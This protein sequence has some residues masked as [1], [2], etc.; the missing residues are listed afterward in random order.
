MMRE[1][2]TQRFEKV[3]FEQYASCIGDFRD[4]SDYRQFEYDNIKRPKRAT[5]GSAGY[6]FFAPHSFTLEVGQ[7]IK[8]PTGIRVKLKPNKVLMC[9]PRSGH[10]FKY[11]LQMDN[12][13]G[14]IDS[15]YYYSDNEGHIWA[16][17]TN[18]GTEGKVVEVK[19]G[20]AFM[21]GIIMEYDV[22]D[23]DDLDGVRNGGFGST[24]LPIQEK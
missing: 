24:D 2:P 15:D 20:E 18:D 10:G 23:D 22:T 17:L 3:S 21:Q 11:R 16:K 14:V 12:T 13:V 1:L 6:D 8:I 19:E 5:K 4:W 9:F 7:T